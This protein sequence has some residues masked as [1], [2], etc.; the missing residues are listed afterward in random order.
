STGDEYSNAVSVRGRASERA[1]FAGDRR[2]G[3]ARYVGVFRRAEVHPLPHQHLTE[4]RPWITLYQM[5]RVVGTGWLHD[6]VSG[7]L[8]RSAH[9]RRRNKLHICCLTSGIAATAA[10]TQLPR[11]PAR[12]WGVRAMSATLKLTF[13]Y[14]QTAKFHNEN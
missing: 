2:T 3:G 11:S 12:Q 9:M 1:S 4:Q 7:L 5:V 10:E 6:V 13:N 14:S 8:R